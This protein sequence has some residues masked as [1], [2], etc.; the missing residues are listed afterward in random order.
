M[1]WKNGTITTSGQSTEKSACGSTG[2]R[3]RAEQDVSPVEVIFAWNRKVR[4][5]N[6]RTCGFE[7]FPKQLNW[8]SCRQPFFYAAG[9]TAEGTERVFLAD[10]QGGDS[11][12]PDGRILPSIRAQTKCLPRLLQKLAHVTPAAACRTPSAAGRPLAARWLG[13]KVCGPVVRSTFPASWQ[14]SPQ[15]KQDGPIHL[16]YQAPTPDKATQRFIFQENDVGWILP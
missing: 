12:E 6:L 5:S 11:Q 2:K 8:S 16:T 4:R 14:P 9:L 3:C 13:H 15:V 1:E 10:S 7:K